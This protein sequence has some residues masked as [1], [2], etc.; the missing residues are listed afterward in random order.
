[1]FPEVFPTSIYS[2]LA[3]SL[4]SNGKRNENKREEKRKKEKKQRSRGGQQEVEFLR[5]K[6]SESCEIPS[7]AGYNSIQEGRACFSTASPRK[8]QPWPT[9]NFT[10]LTRRDQ[11]SFT[12]HYHSESLCQEG[13]MD[14]RAHAGPVDPLENSNGR[15]WPRLCEPRRYHRILRILFTAGVWMRAHLCMAS[16]GTFSWRV[17]F[18]CFL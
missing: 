13:T 8:D 16:H 5:S 4:N 12:H 6:Y 3:R 17:N 18:N 9:S 2:F 7:R 1:M 10:A 14:W 15:S 11:S